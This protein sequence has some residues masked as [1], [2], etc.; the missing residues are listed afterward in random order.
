MVNTVKINS[1]LVLILSIL[2]LVSREASPFVGF[3][4]G[5]PNG[6]VFT[7]ATCHNVVPLLNPFGLD[8]KS[9]GLR[10]S[11]PLARTDS[12]GD[13]LTNGTELQDPIGTWNPGSANPG[14]PALVTNPGVPNAAPASTPSPFRTPTPEPKFTPTGLISPSFTPTPT[15]GTSP[16]QGWIFYINKY[17][18]QDMNIQAMKPD[19]SKIVQLAKGPFFSISSSRDGSLLA[20]S[21]PHPLMTLSRPIYVIPAGGGIPIMISPGIGWAD[22]ASFSPDN[23]LVVYHVYIPPAGSTPTPLPFPGLVNAP[24][25]NQADNRILSS[26]SA[27]PQAQLP[28]NEFIAVARADGSDATSA[29]HKFFSIDVGVQILPQIWRSPDWHPKDKNRIAVS[30]RNYPQQNGTAGLFILNAK[31]TSIKSLFTPNVNGI[32]QD[33]FPTWSPDGETLA[34]VRSFVFTAYGIAYGQHELCVMRGDGSDAPGKPITPSN[35]AATNVIQYGIMNPCWSP[36]GQWLAFSVAVEGYY[37]PTAFDLYRVKRDG[38]ELKRLTF[39]GQGWLPEWYPL[40]KFPSVSESAPSPTPLPIVPPTPTPTRTP[41]PPTPVTKTPTFSPAPL[42]PTPTAVAEIT[43]SPIPPSPTATPATTG[44]LKPFLVYEFEKPTLIES[45][46]QE[47]PG[48]FSN[49]LPGVIKLGA[50]FGAPFS[51]SSDNRGLFITVGPKQVAFLYAAQPIATGG[52]PVF[53]R[54]PI[55]ADNASASIALAALKGNLTAGTADGSIATHIPATSGAFIAGER[56][57]SLLYEPDAGETVTPVIQ[58][59]AAGTSETVN[60]LID[61][62]EIYL[63]DRASAYPGDLFYAKP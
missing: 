10:W 5:I 7:C 22:D 29:M 11:P 42:P 53:M 12:D 17:L 1:R 62:L 21:A 30:I 34:Y 24:D 8:Y 39:D 59:A 46:W 44:S 27:L 60:V 48:G 52:K 49:A 28:S 38:T 4:D 15:Q 51:S 25:H 45:G 36:D 6:Q 26:R 43:P 54:M 55:R 19:G 9:N 50:F 3:A 63:I 37:D 31:D 16:Q 41:L 2:V 56:W 35:L 40:D 14:N 32:E 20:F 61:K 47:Y 33:L 57:L 18:Q 13:G 23:S 58:V